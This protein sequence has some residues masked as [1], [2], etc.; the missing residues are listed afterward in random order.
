MTNVT[1]VELALIPA[2]AALAGVA[3]GTVGN[4]YLDRRKDRRAAKRQRDQAI[5][6]LL[7]ATVDLINGVQMVRVAY[8]RQHPSLL[9]N[10][11]VGAT[12]IAAAGSVMTSGDKLSWELLRDWRSMGP[13]LDRLLAADRELD[14]KQRIVALDLATIVAP[15]T[16]RFYAAVAVLTLGPDMKITDVVRDLTPAVGALIEVIAADRKKYDRARAHADEA[17]ERFRAVADKRR[18]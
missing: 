6:E 7:T 8:Y 11:R 2:G 16:V 10:I 18:R 5:A 1:P 12:L 15:R 3:L 9:R 17:L 4:A 13:G 14:E